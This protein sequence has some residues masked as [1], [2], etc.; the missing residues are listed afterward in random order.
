MTTHPY[1]S[2]PDYVFWRRSLADIEP[3]IVDPVVRFPFQIS[4][5]DKVSTGGSCFAQHIARYLAKSGYNYFIA[6]RGHPVLS[7]EALVRFNYGVFSA[8]YGNIYTSR[9]LTQL[10][11]R[12]YGEFK[13][14]DDIWRRDD[15][16]IL[17]PYR[18]TIQPN[19]FATLEELNRDRLQH[20]AAV[21]QVIEESDVFVFTLGL[22]ESWLNRN[23]G[24]AYPI[25]P[26]VSGG[27]FDRTEH[28]FHNEDVSEVV[29]NV[30]AFIVAMRARNPRVR[31]ILTVSPVPLA[32]TAEDRHVLVSTTYSKS[33]LRVAA[34]MLVRSHE[35]VGYFP[36]YEII[37]GNYSRGRYYARNLR[38]VLETGV[39][40]VMALFFKHVTAAGSLTAELMEDA[41]LA[42]DVVLQRSE[43]LAKVVCDEEVLE[44]PIASEE[45]REPRLEA[46][47]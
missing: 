7:Q 2:A 14:V 30:S 34:E 46:P 3:S 36:S 8:R 13:P 29:S 26:G 10:L 27:S 5:G 41:A 43:A 40:H 9:Q 31:I 23:D 18:P 42:T 24:A 44:M 45:R 19:G 16:R 39:Q 22:T 6:E 21:R 47:K 15:G 25:C 35:G 20:F 17:D 11:L 4:P 28:M 33:V 12:A 37:T 38:D 1:R 32:A